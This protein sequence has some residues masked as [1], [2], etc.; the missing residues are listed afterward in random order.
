MILLAAIAPPRAVLEAVASSLGPALASPPPPPPP[1][2]K[3][4]LWNRSS[5]RADTLADPPPPEPPEL[6][7]RPLGAVLLTVTRFGSTTPAEANRLTGVLR[8]ASTEWPNPLVHLEGGTVQESSRGRWIGALVQ[9]DSE[10]LATLAREVRNAAQRV[11][12][13]LDRRDFVPVLPLVEVPTAATTAQVEAILETL[14]GFRGDSWSVGH[15]KVVVEPFQP[16]AEPKEYASIPLGPPADDR[17]VREVA[18]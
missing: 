5:Q 10:A 1:P 17:A 15:L 13:L 16:G 12:Y 9:G 18:T 6:V 14:D 3:R 7:V 8:A 11:G 2:T 4:R